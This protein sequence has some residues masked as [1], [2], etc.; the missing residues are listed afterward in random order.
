MSTRDQLRLALAQSLMQ[1]GGAPG[2]PLGLFGNLARTVAGFQLQKKALDDIEARKQEA[3]QRAIAALTPQPQQVQRIAP[4]VIGE[5]TDE[6]GT[7]RDIIGAKVVNETVMRQ[8]GLTDLL[9]LLADDDTPQAFKSLASAIASRAVAPERTEFEKKFEVLTNFGIS[10]A[11]ALDRLIPGQK[12]SAFREKFNELIKNGKKPSEALEIL[13]KKS[14][15][16]VNVAPGQ[17][18]FAK[19][20]GKTQAKAYSELLERG[21][22]ARN[23]LSRLNRLEQL[24]QQVQSG[25]FAQ[26]RLQFQRFARGLGFDDEFIKKIS[27]SDVGSLEAFNAIAGELTLGDLGKIKGA[28]SEKEL[29]FIQGLQ[30]GITRSPEA[31]AILIR[32]KRRQAQRDIRLAEAAADYV[33]KNGEFG[34]GWEKEKRRLIEADPIFTDDE[35]D[36]LLSINVPAATLVPSGNIPAGDGNAVNVTGGTVTPQADGS[37]TLKLGR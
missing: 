26:P 19:A 27:G 14:G 9:P 12:P 2:S 17:N 11:D 5:A 3:S 33:A 31:N 4:A 15:T 21:T 13:T 16:T 20:L 28:I 36:L 22:T 34:P 1:G 29:S 18:A 7:P 23:A 30:P 25:A 35:R 6:I 24:N 32:I 8:P 37:Y 10:P